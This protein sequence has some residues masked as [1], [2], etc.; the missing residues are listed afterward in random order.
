MSEV[1]DIDHT[2]LFRWANKLNRD[3]ANSLIN[4]TKH[5]DEIKL[6]NHHKEQ[7]AKWLKQVQT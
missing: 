7:I 2:S 1:L 4:N 6:K 3:G 5:E